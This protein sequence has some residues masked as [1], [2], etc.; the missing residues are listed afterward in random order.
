MRLLLLC[1]HIGLSLLDVFDLYM[2]YSG[3]IIELF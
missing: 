3:N 2:G 1:E